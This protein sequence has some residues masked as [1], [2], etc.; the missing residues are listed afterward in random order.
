MSAFSEPGTMSGL[1]RLMLAAATALAATVH[2]SIGYGADVWPVDTGVF[3]C[4]PR[5]PYGTGHKGPRLNRNDWRLERTGWIVGTFNNGDCSYSY[6]VSKELLPDS[7]D[8][9]RIHIIDFSCRDNEAGRKLRLFGW[10]RFPSGSRVKVTF[11]ISGNEL[12]MEGHAQ[13]TVTIQV[14]FDPIELAKLT[15]SA[16]ESPELHVELALGSDIVR[17]TVRLNDLPAALEVLQ[18]KCPIEPEFPSSRPPTRARG[19]GAIDRM[20]KAPQF[21]T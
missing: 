4:E 3:V 9:A 19:L 12:M 8:R 17:G 6:S 10:H 11:R 15:D 16:N 7:S 14:P 18:D 2:A 21:P 13:G 1:Q 20:T 5:L